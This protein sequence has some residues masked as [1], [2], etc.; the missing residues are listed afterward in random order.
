MVMLFEP[1]AYDERTQTGLH[2][3]EQVVITR[4][5]YRRLGKLP[6]EFRST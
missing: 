4:D 2:L 1:A 6:L 3:S 5:G